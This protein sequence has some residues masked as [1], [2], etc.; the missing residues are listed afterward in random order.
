V[1]LY[2]RLLKDMEYH[3][4]LA[5][6]SGNQV[7]QQTLKNLFDL[8][9]LKYGG[10]FLFS[11]SMENADTDHL[12]LFDSINN[13]DLKKAR[14][15]LSKHIMSVKNHVIRGVEQLLAATRI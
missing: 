3:L 15:V 2:D 11:S 4:T 12:N 7:Q 6:L 8:L 13:G 14:A 5:S 1:Y 9:Y 10:K